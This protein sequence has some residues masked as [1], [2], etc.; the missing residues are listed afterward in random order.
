ML[1][2]SYYIPIFYTEF[3]YECSEG[4]LNIGL[5]NESFFY[6]CYFTGQYVHIRKVF[7]FM[8]YED[9]ILGGFK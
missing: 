5:F 1:I 7:L 6:P 2:L 8:K 3:Q 9:S 4:R